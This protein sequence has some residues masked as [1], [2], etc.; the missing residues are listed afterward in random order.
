MK[1][2]MLLAA[3]L[4]GGTMF[5]TAPSFAKNEKIAVIIKATDSSGS[6]WLSVQRTMRTTIL[7]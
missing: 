2:R 1:K 5:V 3:A 6:I 7:G 4:I